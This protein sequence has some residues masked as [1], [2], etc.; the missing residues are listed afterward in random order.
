MRGPISDFWGKLR[1]TAD[2]IEWHPWIDHSADVAAVCEALLRLTLIRRRLAVLGGRED[3]TDSDIA[4]IAA[5]TALHD[6]GKPNNGFQNKADA[7][8]HPHAGH[9][10]PVLDVLYAFGSVEQRRLVEV[11]ALAELETWAEDNAGCEL[12]IACICHH[13]RPVEPGNHDVRLWQLLGHRDPF[14]G[15][16]RLSARL[17]TWFPAAF[18]SRARPLPSNS[19]FVHALC[20]LVT[21]ADWIGSDSTVFRYSEPSDGDRRDFARRQASAMLRHIGIDASL[22]R[23]ALNSSRPRF[24]EIFGFAPNA[25]QRRA[26]DLP[27]DETGRLI[28][29]ESQTGSGKTE[30]AVAH[31]LK[32]FSIGLVDGMYFALPTRTAAVQMYRRVAEAVAAAFSVNAR[33]PVVQRFPVICRVTTNRALIGWRHSIRCGLTRRVT[34]AIGPQSIPSATWP[35][36]LVSAQSISRCSQP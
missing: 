9:V 6:V 15:I 25:M 32:L 13:G 8:R 22:A 26:L 34:F 36:R 5:F 3:L 35:A 23:V 28:I 16:A 27:V 31:F 1:R 7:N 2:G 24:S 30:A 21:L 29:L 10:G 4:R 11:L 14:D 19:E 33:P 17:R 18:D 20:G 12:L